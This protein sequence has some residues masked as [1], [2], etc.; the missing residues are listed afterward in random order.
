MFPAI[1][2]AI[3]ESRADHERACRMDQKESCANANPVAAIG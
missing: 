1:L 2:S 3:G